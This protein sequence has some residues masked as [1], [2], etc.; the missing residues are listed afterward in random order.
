M[1]SENKMIDIGF[2]FGHGESMMCYST[3]ILVP[4]EGCVNSVSELKCDEN[5]NDVIPTQMV[6]TA[7]QM[8]KLKDNPYPKRELLDQLGK[9]NIGKFYE[10]DYD[11]GVEYERFMY[12]KSS[13]EI[14]DTDSALFGT[15]ETAKDCHI[16]SSA[17]MA[18]YAYEFLNRALEYHNKNVLFDI[19]DRENVNLY[20]GCPSSTNWTS[21]KNRRKY[22]ELIKGAT[23]V[24]SVHV[25]PESRAAMF[26]SLEKSVKGERV[27]ANEGAIV[28]D[29]G[30]S[31]ADC[32]Y[33]MLGRKLFDFSW[34]L[35]A[36][37]IEDNLKDIVQ[38]ETEKENPDFI[39]EPMCI[40]GIK[41]DLRAAKEEYFTIGKQIPVD[42]TFES[43]FGSS[44]NTKAAV[45]GSL[46]ALATEDSVS[47]FTVAEYSDYYETPFERKGTWKQLC[48]EFFKRA[49]EQI[50]NLTYTYYDKNGEKKE[51]PCGVEN[52][53]LTGGA[54][55][56]DFIYELC[57]KVFGAVNIV[58]DPAQSSVVAKGLCWYAI[59]NNAVGPSKTKVLEAVKNNKEISFDA[60]K[61]SVYEC[62]A[63]YTLTEISRLAQEW[64]NDPRP[65][66]PQKDLDDSIEKRLSEES[67]K[68]GMMKK[69]AKAISDWKESFSNTLYSELSKMPKS[70]F[71]P[72]ITKSHILP[73]EIWNDMMADGLNI[74][75]ENLNVGKIIS[76]INISS[77]FRKIFQSL[78]SG[79]T[80]MRSRKARQKGIVKYQNEF[81]DNRSKLKPEVDKTLEPYRKSYNDVVK[82]RISDSI[83]ILL[84]KRF[85]INGD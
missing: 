23:G 58:K 42:I 17:L 8:R 56:M 45:D 65:K 33:M 83:E 2:D 1:D 32:T 50:Q 22:E 59:C 25:V 73:A 29:F 44:Y 80:A 35:G 43:V 41:D 18:C 34:T 20:V 77:W 54:S 66:L 36:S 79:K 67:F 47:E 72:N 71:P 52:I 48:E 63:K 60:L 10:A 37:K 5:G 19:I 12:F 62:V 15:S 61:N 38:R 9:I 68:D 76:Q 75:I 39:V 49:K 57:K 26:R 21:E 51:E 46:M 70:I 69:C 27:S 14:F 4:D 16:T 74:E 3:Q 82:K 11:D 55:Q 40:N 7:E 64:A 85:D 31:T 53:I 30:S 6:L 28:F 24:N 84:L 13:P 78:N 81:I